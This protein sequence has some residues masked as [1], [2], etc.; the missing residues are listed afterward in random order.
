MVNYQLGKIYKMESPSGKI[1][2][3]STC[4]PTLARRLAKH[5]G[6]FIHWQNGGSSH[7]AT[8][9]ELFK[10][11]LENTVIFLLEDFPCDNK[12]QLHAREGHYIKSSVCVNKTVAGRKKKESDKIYADK[13]KEKI[14]KYRKKYYEQNKDRLCKV[15]HEYYEKNKEA[16]NEKKKKWRDE[17]KDTQFQYHKKYRENNIDLIKEK[18]K[19]YYEQNKEKLKVLGSVQHV[20]VCGVPFTQ[21][22]KSRHFK[23]RKHL[24]F[25]NEN[26]LL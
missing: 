2:I 16:I 13:N 11:D 4:E 7:Y 8:S 26:K 9:F 3:G 1:Y 17:N 24:A 23:S 20:C 19:K 25:T 14:Q 6:N 21:Y 22:N 10:E 12:D 5:K 18:K 15:K